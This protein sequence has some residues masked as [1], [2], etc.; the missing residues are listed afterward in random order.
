LVVATHETALAGPTR[1]LGSPE[2]PQFYLPSAGK[3]G[4]FAPHVYGAALIRF[5]NRK[6]KIDEARRVAVMVRLEPSTRTL[7]WDAAVPVDVLPDALLKDPPVAAPYLP[8]PSGAM[9]LKVFTRWA[10]QFDRWLARTQKLDVPP[11]PDMPDVTS[12][13]PKRGGVSVDLLAI[14]WAIG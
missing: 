4:V 12:I 9:D 11:Q 13:G 2:I 3:R 1:P 7:D 8:L 10:K 5:G 14:V 6:R